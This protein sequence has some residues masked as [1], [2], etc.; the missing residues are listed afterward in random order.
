MSGESSKSKESNFWTNFNQWWDHPIKDSWR[1][2]EPIRQF[3]IDRA[4]ILTFIVWVILIWAGQSYLASQNANPFDITRWLD[5]RA[6]GNLDPEALRNFVWAWSFPLGAL[7]VGLTVVNALRRTRVMEQQADTE[8]AKAETSR[9]TLNANTFAESVKLLGNKSIS[10][11]TGGI[12]ALEGLIRSEF[13]DFETNDSDGHFGTQ[14]GETL[15]SYI[16]IRSELLKVTLDNEDDDINS[17]FLVIIRSWPDTHRP[18]FKENRGVNLQNISINNLNIP[19]NSNFRKI[20]FEGSSFNNVFAFY[21]LLNGTILNNC[22]IISSNFYRSYLSHVQL[23]NATIKKTEYDYTKLYSG[24]FLYTTFEKCSFKYAILQDSTFDH[25]E[26]SECDLTG[27]NFKGA[28]QLNSEAINSCIWDPHNPP[29]LPEYLELP[30]DG[31][32]K[33]IEPCG[34]EADESGEKTEEE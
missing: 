7:V 5:T 8:S 11:R 26:F 17:A 34:D 25:T 14:I 3:T 4:L 27:A 13:I 29:I 22:K 31:K 24:S 1:R 18:N 6:H 15:A 12:Y 33:P 23:R 32:G 21:S 20:N 28:K 30:H 2:T 10:V 9:D 16:R 19:S